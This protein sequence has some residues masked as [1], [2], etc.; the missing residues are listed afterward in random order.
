MAHA[1]L[2]DGVLS[3]VRA[4]ADIVDIVGQVTPLKPAGKNYKGLCPFHR[5]KTPSFQVDRDKGLFY[6]F[7]CQK[8]GDVFTFLML[9]ERFTFPEAVEH[10]AARVGIQLPRRKDRERQSG[11]DELLEI[12]EEASAAYHQSLQWSPNPAEEY[13][14]K[15][16]VEPE[17]WR[18]YGFGYAPDSWDYLLSR[19]GRKHTTDK[20]EA[21]GLVLPRKSGSGHYD[22]FR[23][24]LMVPIHSEAGNVIGFGGRSLDGSDPKYLNSPETAIFNKSQLLYNLHRAKDQIRKLERAILVEGYFDCIALDCAGV[25]GVVASMGTSLTPGQ[26]SLLRRF[27]KRVI[28]TYDGD[29]AGRN[30]TLRAGPIFLSAGLSVDVIDVGPG[31]DPDTFIH[32]FGVETVMERL[33]RAEDIFQYSL[34]RWAANVTTM[35][36]REKSELLDL[37]L[38]LL[39][40]V[41]DP[42]VRNDAAQRVA[43]R[44]RLEFDTVWSRMKLQRGDP[45][46]ST[47]VPEAISTGEKQLLRAVLSEDFPKPLLG[48]IREEH[49]QDDTCREIFKVVQKI[50]IGDQ[51]LDFSAIATHL[52]GEAELTRLSELAL[53]DETDGLNP[54]KLEETIRL[55]ER[56]FLDGRLKE[57]Q[58]QIQEA[59]RAGDH[60]RVQT[61]DLEKINLSRRLHLK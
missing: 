20:L 21:A 17:S 2:N 35:T 49:F 9:A 37:F 56:R 7:G 24:R 19:L 10:V 58:A 16:E 30:A 11:K 39:S 60:E 5:E 53:G 32:K 3:Q 40:S 48:Q 43:D 14:K 4:A 31:E 25:P 12:L 28:I 23:N 46:R 15:R 36:S 34:N 55:M 50:G 38:P 51:P 33:A 61:L 41:A 47:A 29:D 18:K 59:M 45:S 13:L 54:K 42:V 8:G 6:C 27:A 22:R 57:I 52:K 44:L 1:D 26:A